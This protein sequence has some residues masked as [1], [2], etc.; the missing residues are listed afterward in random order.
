[1]TP[2][3]VLAP[4][5]EIVRAHADG[6]RRQQ[7]H[8]RRLP[9]EAEVE[10]DRG[11]DAVQVH[12]DRLAAP[13]IRERPLQRDRKA[14]VKTN[15]PSRRAISSMSGARGS[16]AWSGMPN[17]G[18]RRP[19]RPS[20]ATVARA[21]CPERLILDRWRGSQGGE[22]FGHQLGELLAEPS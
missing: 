16:A 7:E 17:P 3:R 1:M 2:S 15:V 19:S 8:A 20:A 4:F 11:A 13:R 5:L 22:A 10:D 6:P 14:A 12:R 9:G 18:S 21:F